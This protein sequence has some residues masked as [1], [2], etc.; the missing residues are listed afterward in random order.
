[1]AC[2]QKQKRALVFRKPFPS[3][4]RELNVFTFLN[5]VSWLLLIQSHEARNYSRIT[6]CYNKNHYEG[7]NKAVVYL[8]A[9]ACHFFKNVLNL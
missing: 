3:W 6:F 5:L 8:M 2:L 7:K 4:K 1:M 9:R